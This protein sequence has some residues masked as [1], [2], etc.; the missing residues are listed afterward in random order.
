MEDLSQE[1]EDIV[2]PQSPV[3]CAYRVRRC[4]LCFPL[5]R[6]LADGGF[7]EKVDQ[8]VERHRRSPFLFG[9]RTTDTVD[10]YPEPS[11]SFGLSAR[12][13]TRGRAPLADPVG[14]RA[15]VCSG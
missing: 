9:H 8:F 13:E 11:R 1:N 7:S 10:A 15:V 6:E 14:E 4:F 12:G 2:W 3:D 5:L